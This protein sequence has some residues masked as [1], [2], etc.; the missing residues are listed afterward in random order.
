MAS[1]H[2]LNLAKEKKIFLTI[3]FLLLVLTAVTVGV[4]YIHVSVKLGIV[5]ALIVAS[6]K[7][8]LV[9]GYFMHLFH[10]K[11]VIFF[12]LILTGIF[13]LVLIILPVATFY[14]RL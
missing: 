10:E 7:A 4:S 8:T 1:G 2:D 13:F 3:Y 6:I 11:P 12:T 14:D 5:I 9:A